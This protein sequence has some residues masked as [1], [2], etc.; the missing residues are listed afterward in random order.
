MHPV[1]AYESLTCLQIDRNHRLALAYVASPTTQCTSKNSSFGYYQ[2]L[3]HIARPLASLYYLF[4][5]QVSRSAPWM[6]RHHQSDCRGGTLGIA[7][8]VILAYE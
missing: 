8:S 1:T 5:R 3:Q 4:Q 7:Q 2:D 6:G